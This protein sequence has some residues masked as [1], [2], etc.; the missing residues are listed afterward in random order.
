[1]RNGG[2]YLAVA[3]SS[4]P[5][6]GTEQM[7]FRQ[8]FSGVFR[9]LGHGPPHPVPHIGL[10]CR[11]TPPIAT[12]TTD[13]HEAE[14]EAIREMIALRTQG[15]S[16]RAIAAAMQA[17]GHRISHEGVAGV[18]RGGRVVQDQYAVG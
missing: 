13:V 8:Q 16:L 4:L 7:A 14:Q 15:A 6:T 10:P 11:P 1:M 5:H 2:F 17:K 18:L 9:L 3:A 12:T